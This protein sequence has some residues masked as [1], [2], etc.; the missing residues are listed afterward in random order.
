MKIKR[1]TADT[2]RE[3][4]RNVRETWGPDA[5]ILS[6]KKLGNGVEITAAIDFEEE[7]VEQLAAEMERSP[8]PSHTPPTTQTPTQA[9]SDTT[10]HT[11]GHT[12]PVRPEAATQRQAATHSSSLASPRPHL[13]NTRPE[14]SY[15]P[16][17]LSDLRRE[18]SDLR[19][20]IE[21]ELTQMAWREIGQK[22]PRKA[23]LM[24]KLSGLGLKR[25]LCSKVLTQH[26]MPD[27]DEAAWKQALIELASMLTEGDHQLLET[28]GTYAI[29][30][31]T[32]VG[33]TTTIA[34]LAAQYAL[35]HGSDKI[36]LI[37]TDC[38][39]IGG[40]DQLST[41]GKLLDIPVFL[42]TDRLELS[43]ILDQLSDKQL[44][45]IDTAGMSQRDMELSKQLAT[46]TGAG[47]NIQ[48]YLTLSA[49]AQQAITSEIMRVFSDIQLAGTVVTKVDEAASLGGVLN[50][51]IHYQLPTFFISNGQKVPEDLHLGSAIELVK[52]ARD[53]LQR[54]SSQQP[55]IDPE[56]T[57]PTTHSP[58][59]SEEKQ[60]HG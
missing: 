1:F 24:R 55:I 59:N 33:K 13:L 9:A 35:R 6:N 36:G 4:I 3:A 56:G 19:G 29:I 12:T 47:H 41:F 18:I 43:D 52:I 23:A 58:N 53:L 2:M 26:P 20:L 7:E 34:K 25:E 40:V 11:T 31:S 45:L 10:R 50:A 42:A 48:F 14:T 22:N 5:V 39:R 32:G 51:L 44:I 57:R 16:D 28:G 30:G 46:L 17:S 49:T 37:T 8:A 54:S 38:F 60:L 27:D 21:G 15:N